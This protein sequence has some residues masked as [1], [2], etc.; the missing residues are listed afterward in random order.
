M[1][2]SDSN[3][4]FNISQQ[5]NNVVPGVSPG[6]GNYT[7]NYLGTSYTVPVVDVCSA[8]ITMC[9]AINFIAV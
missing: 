3:F 8:I 1:S 2:Y 6:D 9:Y 7:F 4:V 5:V